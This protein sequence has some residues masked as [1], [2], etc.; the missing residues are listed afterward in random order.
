M[1]WTTLSLIFLTCDEG[2]PNNDYG[3][4][5]MTFLY[6]TSQDK[7]GW[8]QFC[9]SIRLKNYDCIKLSVW[10]GLVNETKLLRE[11]MG[12]FTL[13]IQPDGVEK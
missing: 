11:V 6:M 12:K 7:C 8:N 13:S 9:S 3:I 5:T 10:C 2:N 1:V 4:R